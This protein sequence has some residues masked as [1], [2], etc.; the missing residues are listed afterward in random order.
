[1]KSRYFTLINL[2]FVT[3]LLSVIANAKKSIEPTMYCS[4]MALI[5]Q[6][7]PWGENETPKSF[8]ADRIVVSKSRKKLYLLNDGRIISDY[9]VS[10]GFGFDGGAKERQG[11]GRTP[12]GLYKI[13]L[14]K[15]QTSYH[16]ALQVSYPN[17]NDVAFAAKGGFKPGGDILIHGF[18]SRPI[19]GLVPENVRSIHGVQNWTQGCMGVTNEEIEEI[20]KRVDAEVPLEICP[21]DT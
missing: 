14:K 15:T 21:I 2:I 20:F 6:A 16:R 19:D 12:E 1:M 18:P 10:F 4:N 11:D 8:R 17:K 7:K 9:N 13:A 3:T 5:D